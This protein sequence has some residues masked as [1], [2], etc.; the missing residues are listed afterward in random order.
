MIVL[1]V[2]AVRLSAAADETVRSV[3]AAAEQLVRATV[4]VRIAEPGK[5]TSETQLAE[6]T[7]RRNGV[8][9]ITVCSGVSLGNGLLVTFH[10]LPFVAQLPRIRVT[11]P[12]GEQAE[13]QLRVVDRHTGLLLLEI[14]DRKLPGLASAG[15]L[16]KAG[17]VVVTAAAAGIERPA[18]SAGILG[19]SERTL[20]GIDLPPL[21]QCDVR[22]TETS[23][24]SAVV[25]R[26]GKLLGIVAATTVP[27]QNDSWTY[28]LPVRHVQRLL[29]A[30]SAGKTVE[31]KRRRPV[32]GFTLGGADRPGVVLVERV[33][34]S[35]PAAAAGIKVGDQ[36]VET[37]GVKIRSAYQAI[38]LILKKLPG[39][40][41]SLAVERGG[42][43]RT[44]ELQL[45][46]AESPVAE[47]SLPD[48]K[49]AVGSRLKAQ[50]HSDGQITVQ[51]PRGIAEVSVDPKAGSK[52]SPGDEVQMLRLQLQAYELL[53]RDMQKEL[54]QLRS[55]TNGPTEKSRSK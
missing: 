3:E 31:L 14:D 43:R 47:L 10:P 36:L 25:D 21:L 40:A 53:I 23:C 51:N 24:G 6:G 32:V 42:E 29:R 9:Q 22:T 38:D 19:A 18:V 4:T 49:L 12:D 45:G 52:L 48:G 55:Q 39:E 7:S 34:K 50:T 44:L 30:Q 2:I 46:G 11:L 20:A 13:A 27:G 1:S 28:A 54:I 33:D 41:L 5:G 17:G 35:G 8:E 15:E 26:H 37:E 16:P